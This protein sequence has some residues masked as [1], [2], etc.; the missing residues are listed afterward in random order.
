MQLCGF[1]FKNRTFFLN[2]QLNGSKFRTNLICMVQSLNLSIRFVLFVC[3]ITSITELSGQNVR[4]SKYSTNNG[5]TD[6]VVSSILQDQKG[7]I[8]F[9]TE[10]G[11]NRFDGLTFKTYRANP[12]IENSLLNPNVYRIYNDSK[13]RIWI[14]Y[15]SLAV[16]TVFDPSRESFTHFYPD[17]SNPE[18]L[19]NGNV[20]DIIEDND[21][22]IWI[23]T[24]YGLNLYNEDGSFK[25][26]L[27]CGKGKS[28]SD[29]RLFGLYKDKTGIIWIVS[30]SGYDY[31]N[32]A[33]KEFGHLNAVVF[34]SLTAQYFSNHE[35]K[36]IFF[37]DSDDKLWFASSHYLFRTEQSI[38]SDPSSYS[39]K[40]ID[41]Q[42]IP[43]LRNLPRF[44]RS[45][46]ETADNSIWVSTP[47]GLARL[48]Q[49][50][51]AVDAIKNY[52]ADLKYYN[53]A[54]INTLSELL[55]SPDGDIWFSGALGSNS[56]G[57]MQYNF[58]E[59]RF[60]EYRNIPFD[61]N[62]ISP[63]ELSFIFIDRS[64]CLWVS[65]LNRGINVLDLNRKK[66]N[67]FF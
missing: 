17:I 48:R 12:Q 36:P 27:K 44:I 4:F 64:G 18:R 45:I 23:A 40:T 31:Y 50:E 66:F 55:K 53:K 25:R 19:T 46:E 52:F 32:P 61:I 38:N 14:V 60:I 47:Y 59:D 41:I 7:F 24:Q 20:L 67:N 35:I 13:N 9:G 56:L 58:S 22:N 54:S 42:N 29:N 5:L 57:L 33:T 16:L 37:C 15:R 26:Y 1:R 62:S 51:G 63:G 49:N 43:V 65:V 11:L 30:H 2:G 28:I 10:D 21:Q 6:N 8:W 39:F 3:L 34:D